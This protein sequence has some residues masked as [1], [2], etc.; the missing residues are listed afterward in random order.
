MDI[1]QV[2]AEKIAAHTRET[3]FTPETRLGEGLELTAVD[4]VQI[5]M[6][7]EKELGIQTDEVDYD[8]MLTMNV[9]QLVFFIK[10]FVK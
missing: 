10:S 1:E 6:A 3:S 2:V 8:V 7:V 5:I 4:L 9:S